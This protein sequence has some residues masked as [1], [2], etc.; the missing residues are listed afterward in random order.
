VISRPSADSFAVGHRQKLMQ[1]EEIL[2]SKG[3]P[4]PLASRNEFFNE[5]VDTFE[6]NN[7]TKRANAEHEKK[8]LKGKGKRNQQNGYANTVTKLPLT[9][10]GAGGGTRPTCSL[11]KKLGY[12]YG[13]CWTRDPTS[14]TNK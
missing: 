2:L 12:L 1:A 10:N 6:G 9:R 3:K 14:L 8:Q 13:Q 7:N 4:N 5:V 11:C